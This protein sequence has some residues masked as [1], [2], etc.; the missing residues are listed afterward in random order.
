M[1]I[2]TLTLYSTP[3]TPSYRN[4]LTGRSSALSDLE[5]KSVFTQI[6]NERGHEPLIWGLVDDT[7]KP[8]SFKYRNSRCVVNVPYLCNDL[9]PY[10]YCVTYYSRYDSKSEKWVDEYTY[11]F[12]ESIESLNDA[13]TKIADVQKPC[14]SITLLRDCW[15]NNEKELHNISKSTEYQMGH[16]YSQLT[17]S[18]STVY[19]TLHPL[20]YSFEEYHEP[21]VY[22]SRYQ[23]LWV[24][25]TLDSNDVGVYDDRGSTTDSLILRSMYDDNNAYPTVLQPVA[26]FDVMLS[27]ILTKTDGLTF[28]LEF[29][30]HTFNHDIEIKSSFSVKIPKTSHILKAEYTFCVPFKY[31]FVPYGQLPS[32]VY[33]ATIINCS[34]AKYMFYGDDN[35]PIFDTVYCSTKNDITYWNNY[36]EYETIEIHTPVINKFDNDIYTNQEIIDNNYYNQKYPQKCNSIFINSDYEHIVIPE[37]I[38]YVILEYYRYRNFPCYRY[39]YYKHNGEI[40]YSLYIP[41]NTNGE[42]LTASTVYD[43]YM[44]NNGNT[45]L[46]SGINNIVKGWSKGYLGFHS[47]GA[48]LGGLSSMIENYGLNKDLLNRQ[49]ILNI[50]SYDANKTQLYQDLILYYEDSIDKHNQ[51]IV[52]LTAHKYGSNTPFVKPFNAHYARNFE[53]AEIPNPNITLSNADD[54]IIVNN[55]LNKGLTQWL[56]DRPD[57]SEIFTDVDLKALAYLNTN[58]SNPYF[59]GSTT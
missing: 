43:S 44:R 13:T 21:I 18:Q 46:Y 29:P 25:Y 27:R 2:S 20:N 12:V 28:K 56:V 59:T 52:A 37:G 3:F 4:V 53:Y 6:S 57:N 10:N 42:F 24:K 47:L 32:L 11:W 23:V 54:T 8:K 41:I 55:A 50:P 22:S 5:F 19:N 49:D 31:T 1:L 35:I 58:V 48:S 15:T 51:E 34:S 45:Q 7:A 40:L 33:V 30:D 9:L 26:V 36:N 17:V 39:A 14:T 38:S 16:A